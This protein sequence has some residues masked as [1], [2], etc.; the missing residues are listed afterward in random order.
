MGIFCTRCG[1]ENTADNAFC[2]NCGTPL[3][4]PGTAAQSPDVPSTQPTPADARTAAAAARSTPVPSSISPRKLGIWI[5]SGVAALALVGGGVYFLTKPPSASA[6]K[7]LVAAQKDLGEDVA[8]K[9]SGTLCLGN[10]N[11]AANPFNVAV[12]DSRTQEWLNVLTTAGLYEKVGTVVG[13]NAFFQQELVQYKPTAALQKWRQGD[14]LC[15]ARTVK[16]ASVTD[17]AEPQDEPATANSPAR[18]T[19]RARIVFETTDLADWMAKPGVGDKMLPQLSNW[20]QGDKQLT[21]SGNANFVVKDGE[22][23]VDTESDDIGRRGRDTEAEEASSGAS[24][25]PSLWSR[26]TSL[27]GFQAHALEGTWEMAE[28][29][30]GAALFGKGLRLKFTADTCEVAGRSVACRFESQGKQVTV[31]AQGDKNAMS[32]EV[33]DDE[34]IMLDAG[35]AK[36]PYKRVK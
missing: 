34:T 11:Y 19:V 24:Q 36:L 3:R 5:G 8:K 4:K 16:I 17:I 22:W 32:F 29:S 31:H 7:L 10:M 2:Q 18:R 26:I 35:L 6:D 28:D 14:E 27:F 30:P 21:R 25:G 13:G 33:V 20:E 9:L 23:R 12:Y 15:L 1:T